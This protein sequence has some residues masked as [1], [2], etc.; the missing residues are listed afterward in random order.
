MH[1][2]RVKTSR[3]EVSAEE[4]KIFVGILADQ[5][6]AVAEIPPSDMQIHPEMGTG[7]PPRY[8]RGLGKL[9]EKFFMVLDVDGVIRGEVKEFT[10]SLSPRETGDETGTATMT[11]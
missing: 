7:I 4:G 2:G 11:N 10:K 9:G 6:M 5:V 3:V 1:S 8:L